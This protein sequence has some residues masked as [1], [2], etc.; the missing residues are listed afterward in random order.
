ML[1]DPTEIETR[2]LRNFKYQPNTATLHTDCRFMPR[3][4]RC[5][6]SWNY[7]LDGDANGRS[8]PTTHYWMNSLQGVSR[9]RNYFVSLNVHDRIAPDKILR[10]IEYEHPLFDLAAVAAQKE[11]PSLNRLSPQQTTYYA[12]AWFKYGFHEDG[13]TSAL[14]CARAITGEPIWS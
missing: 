7:H 11:L 12:G 9:N 6:A 10:R 2:L 14:E 4:P 5:W 3:T 13:F 1:A 8:I